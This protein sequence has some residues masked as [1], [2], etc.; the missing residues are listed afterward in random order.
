MEKIIKTQPWVTFEVPVPVFRN[1]VKFIVTRDKSRICREMSDS[2]F[3]YKEGYFTDYD[4]CCFT[5]I[6]CHP[7]VWVLS[8]PKT[9]KDHDEL[10]HEI[11]HATS[12]ILRNIGLR[13]CEDTE[14]VYCYLQGY[15]TRQFFE[16]YEKLK[17]RK[18]IKTL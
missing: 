12:D 9:P 10:S 15:I 1:R 2:H 13:L 4:G 17:R 18:K 11:T 14:E 3:H 16:H 7:T 5:R 8:A 6:G